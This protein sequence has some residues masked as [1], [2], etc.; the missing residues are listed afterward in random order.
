[1]RLHDFEEQQE[2]QSQADTRELLM[3]S[4]KTQ[5]SILKAQGIDTTKLEALL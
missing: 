1:M 2:A 4:M 5:I 3:E